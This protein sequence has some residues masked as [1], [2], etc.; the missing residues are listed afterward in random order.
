[1]EAKDFGLSRTT[2][3]FKNWSCFIAWSPQPPK[4]LSK[5]RRRFWIEV[6]S[7]LEIK[8]LRGDERNLRLREIGAPLCVFSLTEQFRRK[9]SRRRGGSGLVT[10]AVHGFSK[11]DLLLL[12]N[13]LQEWR[14]KAHRFCKLRCKKLVGLDCE[15]QYP[16]RLVKEGLEVVVRRVHSSVWGAAELGW[17]LIWKQ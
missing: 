11:F 17:E 10:T 8:C 16:L 6:H 13:E 7:P 15:L 4:A 1:M 14:L 5:I 3:G 12:F 9:Q 2:T